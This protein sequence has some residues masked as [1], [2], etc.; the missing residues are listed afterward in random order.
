MKVGFIGLGVMG[1]PMA[2]HLAAA[3]HEMTVF[4]RSR[5][6]AETWAKANRGAAK[7]SEA[8]L[9]LSGRPSVAH[10]VISMPS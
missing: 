8:G 5:G 7:D 9:E 4:N 3:G 1:G 2:G 6:K 10:T